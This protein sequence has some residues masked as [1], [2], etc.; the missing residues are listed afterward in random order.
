[1]TNQY[2]DMNGDEI[3]VGDTLTDGKGYEELV[4]QCEAEDGEQDLGIDATNWDSPSVQQG[5]SKPMCYPLSTIDLSD[6][7]IKAEVAS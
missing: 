6:L 3:K 7:Y 1:M 5:L 4:L 2:F